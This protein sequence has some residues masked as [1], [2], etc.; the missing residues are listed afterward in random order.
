M[1]KAIF[2]YHLF[3]NAGTSLDASL[4]ENFEE[5]VEWVTEEFPAHPGKNRELV[6]DWVRSNTQAQC[7]SSHTALLPVPRVDEMEL[8]PVIFI[9]HPI[10]RIA[11]AYSFEKK[12]GGDGFGAVLARNT[13][14]KG[15]IETRIALG[16]DRQC[17]NFHTDRFAYM[18]GPQHGD[19]LTRAKLAVE[20]LPFVGIV[21]AFDDS[22]RKLE[23]WL[24]EEG[25][26]DITIA[27]KEHNVSRDT[28][29]SIDEKLAEIRDE[30]GED[31]YEFLLENN[32]DDLALY[33]LAK[34]KFDA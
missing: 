9:R 2:H 14:L 30:I 6:K 16:Y 1:K 15:Y 11:S 24:R 3:K 23:T 22:L 5:G 32:A 8:L 19:E 27:P 10:D 34:Q 28:R 21:E 13:S 17:K 31:A 26:K 12:Q 20:H 4:K 18:C 29:K 7:F 25:F 33:E